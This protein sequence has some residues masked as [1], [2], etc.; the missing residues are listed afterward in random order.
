MSFWTAFVVTIAIVAF[1]AIRIAHYRTR[2]DSR[3]NLPPADDAEKAQLRR[4]VDE[5]RDRVRVLERIATDSNTVNAIESRQIAAEI[6][7]LRDRQN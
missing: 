5:L 1:A 4:E 3:A 7:S 6:E 2:Y